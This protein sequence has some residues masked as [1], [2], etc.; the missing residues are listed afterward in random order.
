MDFGNACCLTKSPR[1]CAVSAPSAVEP[2]RGTCDFGKPARRPLPASSTSGAR[3]PQL[4]PCGASMPYV[5]GWLVRSV[6]WTAPEQ[7]SGLRRPYERR[8]SLRCAQS[9][10]WCTFGVVLVRA[11][12]QAARRA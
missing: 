4:R 9:L 11:T 7:M 6:V 5:P 2:A 10:F 3:K 1:T 8:L 12:V